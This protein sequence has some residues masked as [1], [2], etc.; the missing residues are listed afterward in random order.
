MNS[1]CSSPSKDAAIRLLSQPSLASRRW[2][3]S[4]SRVAE[5]GKVAMLLGVRCAVSSARA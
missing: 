2:F 5:F 1:F 4:K 3:S